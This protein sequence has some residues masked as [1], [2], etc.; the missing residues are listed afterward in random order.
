MENKAEGRGLLD[1]ETLRK[2][3][4]ALELERDRDRGDFVE[5]KI[6]ASLVE[7]RG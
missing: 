3:N 2:I 6:N 1:E 4:I 7:G 5:A